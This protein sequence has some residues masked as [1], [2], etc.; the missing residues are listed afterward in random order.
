M[1][2][3]LPNGVHFIPSHLE[4]GKV[5]AQL[6]RHRDNVW[7]L[8]LGLTAEMLSGGE[9]PIIIDCSPSLGVLAFSA[10]FAADMVLVPVA[11]EYL[12][13]NGA[14]LLQRTLAGWRNLARVFHGDI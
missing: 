11:A 8:K 1:I 10:L 12:A 14:N 9:M 6:T 3:S 5:D 7:R 4:L 13:L 2:T